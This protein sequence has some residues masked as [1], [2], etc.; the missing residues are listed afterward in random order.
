VPHF[1]NQ[2]KVIGIELGCAVPSIHHV[3]SPYL[4]DR[5]FWLDVDVEYSGGFCL[6]METKCNLMRLKCASSLSP[7]CLNEESTV[8]LER[9][10]TSQM[11]LLS[12]SR[13]RITVDLLSCS[14]L[15]CNLKP[16]LFDIACHEC[17]HS[18]YYLPSSFAVYGATYRKVSDIMCTSV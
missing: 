12:R 11:L 2:L 15:S 4:D 17:E 13:C 3:S 5:G 10:V 1:I 6:S 9:F 7:S 14:A 16:E 8:K 18:A